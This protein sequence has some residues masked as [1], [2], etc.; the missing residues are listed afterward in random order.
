MR[1]VVVRVVQRCGA[2]FGWFSAVALSICAAARQH[3]TLVNVLQNDDA[4]S[5]SWE[6]FLMCS[7]QCIVSLS[8][9][10]FACR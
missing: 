2:V 1:K 4:E 5:P 3:R 7:C 10:T 6:E 8:R 9:P